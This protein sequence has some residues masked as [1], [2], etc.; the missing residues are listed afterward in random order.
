MNYAIDVALRKG[1][2]TGD[3]SGITL[4]SNMGD[5][6][7]ALNAVHE[8]IPLEQLYEITLDVYTNSRIS[9][10]GCKKRIIELRK[11][12]PDDYL[13]ELPEELEHTDPLIVY[14][15]TSSSIDQKIGT[16]LSWTTNKD[17][18]VWFYQR[19][20]GD[21]HLYKATIYKDKIIAYTNR[22]NEF[23][24]LQHRGVKDIEEV[25]VSQE[26][27]DRA[28]EAHLAGVTSYDDFDWSDTDIE[29]AREDHRKG[30]AVS[31]D[32]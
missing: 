19:L 23:E 18:A 10:T 22:R 14:R 21:K 27:I 30:K 11:V 12:R 13:K 5:A 9:F 29:A 32:R 4:L 28:I 26:D 31:H 6:L 16:E 2:Q 17:V 8:R 20:L 7:Y 24:V 1:F 25:T 15:A 3:W